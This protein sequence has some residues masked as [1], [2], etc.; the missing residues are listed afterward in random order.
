MR[1]A[2][3]WGACKQHFW[4]RGRRPERLVEFDEKIGMWNVFG[5]PEALTILNDPRT[6]SSDLTRLFAADDDGTMA[7][8]NDGNLLQMDG[9]DHRNLRRLVSHVFTPKVVADLEPR[10]AKITHE[11]LDAVA[12]RDEFD[13]VGDLAYPLPVIVIAELLGVPASDRDLFR[14]WV[15]QLFASKARFWEGDTDL[16]ATAEAEGLGDLQAMLDYFGEHAAERRRQPREDLLSKLVHA[17]VDGERL[18]DN[19]VVNFANL[20]LVAGHITTTLLLGNAVLALDLHPDQA[21]A[22]R[23]DRSKVPGVI[24]ETVRILSPFPTVARSTTVDTEIGGQRVP[25]DQM[26]MVWVG[27]ANRDERQF[28]DPDVFDPT[29]D[30]NPH[31]GFGRGVHFCLGAP[32]AR[33]E[34]RVALDILL[35]RFPSLR[36]VPGNPPVFMPTPEMIGARTLP[37][38]TT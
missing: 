11:L 9:Q 14:Q 32:L 17:E 29:R 19:Q 10:I 4:L 6:F 27:A 35:D 13:L 18:T 16:G 23:A 30:P 21:K 37:V 38:R 31:L 5:Y 15:D 12:D 2:E 8:L 24:E 33:L 25:A 36:T 3:E 28:A 22:V 7:R 34:G 20:L 1:V 26:L